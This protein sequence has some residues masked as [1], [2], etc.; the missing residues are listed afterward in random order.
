MQN[1]ITLS[2]ECFSAWQLGVYTTVLLI[3]TQIS[4]VT[5]DWAA[6]LV[7]VILTA[8]TSLIHIHRFIIYSLY[9][10]STH[11]KNLRYSL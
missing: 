3:K 8:R 5:V 1:S 9:I 11:L 6:A 7:I 10:Y 2:C 4:Q